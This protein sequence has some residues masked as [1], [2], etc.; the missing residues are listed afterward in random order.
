MAA[1]RPPSLLAGPPPWPGRRPPPPR[2][3]SPLHLTPP[4][5]P[6]PAD[7]HSNHHFTVI[8]ATLSIHPAAVRRAAAPPR[9]WPSPT[10]P[11]WRDGRAQPARVGQQL[12]RTFSRARAALPRR[13]RPPTGD[14]D[15][16]RGWLSSGRTP[17]CRPLA[18]NVL[19]DAPS[20][21]FVR[22]ARRPVVTSSKTTL[23]SRP[24]AA[25]SRSFSRRSDRWIGDFFA[26]S[27]SRFAGPTSSAYI[28]STA[29]PFG[30]LP[31]PVR[32]WT[33][34]LQWDPSILISCS[35]YRGEYIL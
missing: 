29:A 18:A 24:V 23:K 22:F 3:P 4:P 28:S 6:Q 12:Q 34:W 13:R 25:T 31:V 35:G 14:A 21:R 16:L 17:G 20:R 33:L 11:R 7:H 10:C 2:F 26:P 30:V 8:T 1:R 27:Q 5:S 15:P 9:E 32:S 19:R